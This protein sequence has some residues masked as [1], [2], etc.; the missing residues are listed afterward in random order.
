MKPTVAARSVDPATV[1]D[2]SDPQIVHLDGLNLSR[3]WCMNGIAAALANDDPARAVFV[4]D[5]PFDDIYGARQAGMRAVLRHNPAVPGHD[6]EPD[7]AIDRLP[8][9]LP[10]LEAW[11]GR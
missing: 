6:V 5:R 9:L 11:M 4:G 3:A 2:R 8:E 1:S 7:A 10:H